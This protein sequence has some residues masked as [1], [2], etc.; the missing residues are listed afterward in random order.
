M[1]DEMEHAPCFV[2]SSSKSFSIHNLVLVAAAQIREGPVSSIRR[3]YCICV[4]PMTITYPLL[5]MPAPNSSERTGF[6]MVQN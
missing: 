3:Q 5:S 1:M 4:Q 2:Q 6:N